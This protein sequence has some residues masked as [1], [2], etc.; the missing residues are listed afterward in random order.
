MDMLSFHL[1]KQRSIIQMYDMNVQMSNAQSGT[2]HLRQ[3]IKQQ[4]LYINLT[5]DMMIS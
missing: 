5:T 1:T 3:S 4:K 2:E